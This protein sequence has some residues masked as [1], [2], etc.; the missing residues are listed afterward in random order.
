MFVF[1]V[2]WDI[3]IWG[4]TSVLKRKYKI[5]AYFRR[6]S[7]GSEHTVLFIGKENYNPTYHIDIYR[8]ISYFPVS[9]VGDP[10][11]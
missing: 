1:G 4:V 5:S 8:A 7:L 6:M 9:V 2:A 10:D 3:G 11:L